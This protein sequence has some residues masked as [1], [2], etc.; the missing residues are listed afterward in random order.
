MRARV[1]VCVCVC[2]LHYIFINYIRYCHDIILQ[3]Y[4]ILNRNDNE[5]INRGKNLRKLSS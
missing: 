2:V 1:C 3:C 5:K 4:F